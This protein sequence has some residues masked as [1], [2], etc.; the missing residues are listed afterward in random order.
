MAVKRSKVLNAAGGLGS[1]LQNLPP[2]PIIAQ[3][4]PTSSDF[5]EIGT[6]WINNS[7]GGYFVLTQVVAGVPNWA[8]QSTGSGTFA[9]VTVTGGSGD[10]L[11][12]DAG[13]DTDLGGDLDVAG[14]T[15][16][17]GNLAVT[18]DVTITGDFDITDTAAIS[19]TSTSNTDPAIYL[20]ANG[21]VD[22]TIVLRSDQGTGLDSIYLLSD[23]GGIKAL[24]TGLADVAAINL[25]AQVGG[26]KFDAILTSA[27]NVVGAGADLQLNATGGSIA[28]TATEASATAINISASDAAG[29][30]V[31]EGV[32]GVVLQST[33]AVIGMTSGTG[34]FSISADAAATTVNIGT[35]ADSVKT[36]NIGGTGANIIAIGNTQTGGSLA[37][38]AGMTSG[39]ITIGG[40]G[41]QT[42]TITF[43]GGTGAQT[44]NLATG[45]TGIKT[46]HIAD[47]AI[48]NVVTLGSST[49]AASLTLQAG[50]G[51]L[52]GTSGGTLLLDCAGVLELNSSAGAISIGNDN[53]AQNINVGTAG[54]R[55][56]TLGSNSSTT[57]TVASG[58]ILNIGANAVQQAITIGNS[59]SATSIS[60]NCGTGTLGIGTNAIDHPIVIG[61]STGTSVVQ[62]L[63]GTS[64]VEL[65]AN[66]VAHAITIGNTTGATG[67]S[68]NVGTGALNLGTSAT[69]HA[70]VIGSTTAG[71]TVL[72]NTPTGVSIEAPN[73]Y[74]V[75]SA[76]RGLFLPGSI[77]VIS[78]AGS[79][80][81]SV[82]AGKG[83]LYLRTNGTTTNDRAYINTD[84]GTTWTALTTAA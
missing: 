47:G 79:P 26:I 22:E 9:T 58:S 34:A 17:A 14:N 66:A 30:L 15:A 61:N 64:G 42:G 20:H 35:G 60:I 80:S 12:V 19:L 6:T 46:V 10:V 29:K 52:V 1:P 37:I 11:V 38:G 73:G 16:L 3:A 48:G 67:I 53:I 36:I 4:D 74:Y 23:V 76:G 72:V 68:L 69:A 82:T 62:I 49:G 57:T 70:I 81:G 18:G 83:S 2:E 51:N 55:A 21:G 77:S 25:V 28:I 27:W 56:V 39:T 13:G 44:V 84:S 50:T 65:G 5:A 54:A 45:G 31:L 24:A 40:T 71:T 8:A 7:S 41:L 75:S 33:N 63:A 78:G 32:G 43:G 59:T